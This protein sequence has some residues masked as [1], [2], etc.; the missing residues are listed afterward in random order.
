MEPADDLEMELEIVAHDSNFDF[1]TIS[2]AD[3]QPL[4]GH[5]GYYFTQLTTTGT[6]T[7]TAALNET[8]NKKLLCLQLPACISKQG[9]VSQKNTKNTD[10]KYMDLMFERNHC[11]ALMQWVEQ[12]EY[13]CQDAIDLKKE[14]WFQTE[15]TRDDIETMMTQ[16]TRLYQSGKYVLMRTYLETNKA[17]GMSKC[18]AYDENE[19]GVDLER[20]TS[21]QTII[22]LV[23]IE[24]VKFSAKSFEISLKLIQL[25]VIGKTEKARSSCLIK[26]STEPIIQKSEPLE[27]TTAALN[28]KKTTAT[29]PIEQ[30]INKSTTFTNKQ[31]T[32]I[33]RRPVFAQ[34]N[35][36]QTNVA[37]I[38]TQPPP[39][40]REK[41]LTTTFSDKPSIS[42]P[43]ISQPNKFPINLGNHTTNIHK[44]KLD[45]EEINI[46][47]NDISDTINLKNPNEVYY[48]IY[49]KARDKA[50]Q[51]RLMTMEA[52]LNAKQIK[53]KYMLYDMDDS[54][55]EDEKSD[56]SY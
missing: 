8:P 43:S 53:T 45:I 23:M 48:E 15:L 54:E 29:I 18:I 50:K 24:G 5:A 12:L 56:R 16:I 47:Y 6:G 49:K 26:R 40:M 35:V 14:L 46:D 31:T 52:Y 34:T 44:P 27:K 2:L 19:I 17:N 33:Q 9:V 42:Q 20:L 39:I 10:T 37:P 55:D 36:G 25:M 1:K 32:P 38:K 22:P 13:A 30:P 41:N 28:I 51:Y 21:T 7:G 11:D 4:A 3:P